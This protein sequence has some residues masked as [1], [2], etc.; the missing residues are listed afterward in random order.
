MADN[1]HVIGGVGTA[2]SGQIHPEHHVQHPGQAVFEPCGYRESHPT[3]RKGLNGVR[4]GHAI[5]TY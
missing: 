3:W 5:R 2:Q 4:T 1:G